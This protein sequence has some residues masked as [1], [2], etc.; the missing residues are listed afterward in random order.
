MNVR[1]TFSATTHVACSG[2]IQYMVNPFFYNGILKISF[3]TSSINWI[4]IEIDLVLFNIYRGHWE[5]FYH[6]RLVTEPLTNDG[7]ASG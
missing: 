4:F 7:P 6:K 1:E 3:N 5:L 2:S